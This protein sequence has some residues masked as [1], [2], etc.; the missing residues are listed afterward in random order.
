L[1]E[2]LEY[3]PTETVDVGGSRDSFTQSVPLIT[4]SR[5]LE[6]SDTRNVELSVVIRERAV[7][8]QFD[9]VPVVVINNR[10]R[11]A[12]NPGEL[13]VVLQGPPSVIGQVSIENLEMVIDATGLAP[14]A[15]DYRIAPQV[16]FNPA[17]LGDQLEVLA[18][19]PQREIDVH[20]YDQPGSR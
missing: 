18:T 1:L 3:I 16:R 5:L 15:E 11:V 6:L 12:V 19:Y 4:G 14:R 17:E 20:V 8:E 7:T 2:A 13:S 9:A 10:Y